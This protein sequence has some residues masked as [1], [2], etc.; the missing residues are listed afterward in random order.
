MAWV[1]CSTLNTIEGRYF[2]PTS[3]LKLFEYTVR[4]GLVGMQAGNYQQT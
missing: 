1:N 3:V 4:S 2:D